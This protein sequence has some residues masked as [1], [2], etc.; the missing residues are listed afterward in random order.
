MPDHYPDLPELGIGHIGRG[1][2]ETGFLDAQSVGL[3]LLEHKHAAP[4]IVGPDVG[5]ALFRHLLAYLCT[6]YGQTILVNDSD[7]H[8]IQDGWGLSGGENRAAN[9]QQPEKNSDGTLR[10]PHWSAV[11]RLPILDAWRNRGLLGL[12]TTALHWQF[13]F[14]RTVTCTSRKGTM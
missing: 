5:L 9:R 7:G 8:Q 4:G 2:V 6:G 3:R 13:A 11:A 14:E 1:F 10:S 12:V